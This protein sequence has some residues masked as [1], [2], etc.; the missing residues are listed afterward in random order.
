MKNSE[1]LFWVKHNGLTV[2]ATKNLSPG[3]KFYNEHIS[4]SDNIELRSWNPI[5]CTLSSAILSGLE[6][7]PVIKGTNILYIGKNDG[8]TVSHLSDI[9]EKTG[10]IIFL[11]KNNSLKIDNLKYRK[12]VIIENN[13]D[14][15]IK[16][17]RNNFDT[18][19]IDT[20]ENTQQNFIFE[21]CNNFLK[22]T[23]FLMILLPNLD[24]MKTQIM[25]NDYRKNLNIIQNIELGS[26]QKNQLLLIAQ[27][28]K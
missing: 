8:I 7:L 20:F 26:Y 9:I 19:F 4:Y 2:P 12:N 6:I 13:L 10:K 24:K 23:G 15:L 27:S 16:T 28:I 3:I 5:H 17:S 22:S 1:L 14:E 21:I 11:R 25:I 18:I